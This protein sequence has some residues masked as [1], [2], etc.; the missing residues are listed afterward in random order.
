LLLQLRHTLIKAFLQPNNRLSKIR[1]FLIGNVSPSACTLDTVAIAY[2]FAS[3][4]PTWRSA[5]FRRIEME[6][7]IDNQSLN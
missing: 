7:V 1:A 4:Q 6:T 2:F 5:L 3:V